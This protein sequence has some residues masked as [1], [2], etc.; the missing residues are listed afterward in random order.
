MPDKQQIVTS[1][2]K[3][4]RK[5]GRAPSQKEFN[6]LSDLSTYHVLQHF[7]SW[8]DAVRSSRLRPYTLNIKPKDHALLEDWGRAARRH[9]GVPPRRVYS[10][11][12]K[13]NP[14]TLEKRFGPW[15]RLP[16][17]FRNFAR[18]KREWT[19]VVSLLPAPL[20]PG[21]PP[22][23]DRSHPQDSSSF[24]A[25]PR[26]KWHAP[27]KGRPA[28]GNPTRFAGL[29]HEPINEQG[30]VLLFGML[31]KK[32]GYLVENVQ[33]GFPDC[34]ALRLIAPGRWQRVSIEFEFE[35]RNFRDHG[36]PENGCDV[37]VCWR[38]NWHDCPRHLEILELSTVIKSLSSPG[39]QP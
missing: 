32:L 4:A 1:I 27:R 12:G 30:V 25:P 20:S 9:R 16:E 31:A 34:E 14:R 29:P 36:H 33:T 28:Y 11:E 8:N 13:F 21:R 5:L 35:S 38:H 6:S 7:R 10:R 17:T 39:N 3:I 18:R 23:A 22:A 26:E 19:D 24:S 37:I 2:A 15:S